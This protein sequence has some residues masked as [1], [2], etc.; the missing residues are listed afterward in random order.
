MVA[1]VRTQHL[2]PTRGL[3]EIAGFEDFDQQRKGVQVHGCTRFAA[4]KA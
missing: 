4:H 1:Y 2:Q 3:A